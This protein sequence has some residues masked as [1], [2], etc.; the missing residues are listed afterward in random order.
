MIKK[1]FFKFAMLGLAISI[2]AIGCGSPS[3]K[4]TEMEPA[5]A[6]EPVEIKADM[7]S[8]KTEIQGLESA[9]AAADNARDANALL[10]FYSEDAV[11]LSNNAPMTKGKPAIQKEIEE[12]LAKKTEGETVSYNTIEVF[13]DENTV[14]E[15]G[16]AISKDASGK[17]IRSGKYMAIWEKRDGK[18][19]CIRDIY[20]NDAI[21]K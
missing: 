7:N 4:K 2:F 18:F 6:V 5:V 1:N 17:V 20:N 12:G 16:T 15:I 10:A 13:G 14:T 3:D 9:W 21:E 11:S 8:I 19:I